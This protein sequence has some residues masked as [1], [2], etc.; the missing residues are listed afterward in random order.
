MERRRSWLAGW[1]AGRRRSLN[2]SSVLADQMQQ[3]FLVVATGVSLDVPVQ[4]LV[5]ELQVLGLDLGHVDLVP[6]DDVIDE[7]AV[8]GSN[9]GQGVV[10]LLGKVARPVPHTAD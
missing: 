7:P 10:D 1:L 3:D 9:A 2:Y 8:A 5:V 6:G 4:A